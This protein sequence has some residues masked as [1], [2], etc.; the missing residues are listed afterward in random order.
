MKKQKPSRIQTVTDRKLHLAAWAMAA[1]I[2][3]FFLA[4]ISF[5]IGGLV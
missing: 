3:C 4:A 5:F 2:G 1:V